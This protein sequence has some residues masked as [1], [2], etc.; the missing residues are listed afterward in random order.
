[1]VNGFLIPP[2]DTHALARA[3]EKFIKEPRLIEKMGLKSRELASK[4]YNV[5]EV[6]RVMLEAMGL[7]REGR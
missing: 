1:M 7:R 3:M 2:K 4:K 6:N 5:H